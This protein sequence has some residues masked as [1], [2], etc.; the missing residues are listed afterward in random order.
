[1]ETRKIQKS[2]TTHYLYLP[3]SWCREHNISTDSIV[4]L[5][6]SSRGNLVIQ[7]K[8]P[9]STSS[10][11]KIE[12]SGNNPEVINKM[13]IASYI[14]PIK[15]FEIQLK[16]N[17]DPDQILEHKKL[18][19]GMEL[20]DFEDTK[21]HCQTSLA[22][23]DPDILLLSMIKKILNIVKLMKKDSKHELIKRYEQ[24]VD[25]SNLLIQKS[26][27]TSLMYKRESKLKHVELYYIGL[28]SRI[29]ERLS[30]MLVTLEDDKELVDIIDNMMNSLY[31]LLEKNNLTQEGV[32]NFIENLATL[33]KVIVKDLKTYKQKRVY[34]L[35][36][37]ITETLSDW[38]I[39][40][41]IDKE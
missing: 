13:I 22:L 27:I 38:V 26:I 31:S 10:S 18:L 35:I 14:N 20:V 28:I 29:L 7:P 40:E 32:V 4:H 30:D 24:E 8:K 16:K 12:L 6:K 19:G 15:E 33:D 39:T 34:S 21:I 9:E 36:G 5:S 23:S 2:G 37:H 41:K 11:L 3:A 25:K 17:I 1:M